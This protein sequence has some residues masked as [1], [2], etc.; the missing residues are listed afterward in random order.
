MTDN[1][2]QEGT[3][4]KIY[5]I[6]AEGDVVYVKAADR[7]AAYARLIALMGPIPQSLLTYEEVPKLP[8]GEEFL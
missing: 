3:T 4:M 7:V 5:K 6:T 8:E 1:T 2:T